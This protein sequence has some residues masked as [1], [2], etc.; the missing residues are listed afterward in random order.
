M[1]QCIKLNVFFII[2][3]ISIY[4]KTIENFY[5]ILND[6]P[7]DDPVDV[8]SST[9][10]IKQNK[11]SLASISCVESRRCGCYKGYCWAYIDEYQTPTTGWWCF[12]QQEGIRGKQQLWTKCT[13][14]SQCSWTMT[15]GDCYTYVG[16]RTGIKTD[17]ILC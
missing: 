8:S 10:I 5:E 4:G 12:T 7:N 1:H 17:K 3:I 16:K 11:I 2:L 14:S 6:D 9:P 13:N 15:C